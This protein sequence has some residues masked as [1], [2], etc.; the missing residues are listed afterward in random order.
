MTIWEPPS[1]RGFIK[2]IRS[3]AIIAIGIA[4]ITIGIATITIVIV[5]VIVASDL[6]RCS[7]GL[8]L[9]LPGAI[10]VAALPGFVGSVP[11]IPRC[12]LDV[13][14]IA[15]AIAIAIVVQLHV[16]VREVVVIFRVDGVG[17]HGNSA[18]ER[19]YK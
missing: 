17:V 3:I 18:P 9:C 11:G 15:S 5:I 4:T 14:V 2:S 8:P 19:L 12:M 13:L 6:P 1:R 7:L 10:V 16:L